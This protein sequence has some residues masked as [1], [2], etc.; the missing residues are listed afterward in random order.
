MSG[1]YLQ[2]DAYDLFAGACENHAVPWRAVPG[3][4]GW[5]ILDATG[6]V[7]ASGVNTDLSEFLLSC[8]DQQQRL[9]RILATRLGPL[10]WLPEKVLP[11]GDRD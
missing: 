1:N 11:E 9:H 10:A 7:V 8:A 6:N 3:D 4:T 2:D 5:T